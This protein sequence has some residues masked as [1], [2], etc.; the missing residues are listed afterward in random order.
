[1]SV[2]PRVG[3]VGGGGRGRGELACHSRKATVEIESCP[4]C[5]K[6]TL[7]CLRVQLAISGGGPQLQPASHKVRLIGN[8]VE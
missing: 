4:I 6:T 5:F 1:M 8:E 7:I 2:H 3:E